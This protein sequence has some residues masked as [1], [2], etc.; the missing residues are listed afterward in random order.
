MTAIIISNLLQA[1]FSALGALIGGYIIGRLIFFSGRIIMFIPFFLGF[2]LPPLVISLAL[3][4]VFGF[5]IFGIG[6][7]ILAH[8]FYNIPLVA[9][10]ITLGFAH[11]PV[12]I[13]R[14]SDLCAWGRGQKLRVIDGY[15]LK[16]FGSIAFIMVFIISLSSF[17]LVATM[18]GG[19]FDTMQSLLYKAVFSYHDIEFALRL[20]IFEGVLY[21]VIVLFLWRVQALR[22]VNKM[23]FPFSSL[24]SLGFALVFVGIWAFPFLSLGGALFGASS[25]LFYDFFGLSLVKQIIFSLGIASSVGILSIISA[26]IIPYHLSRFFLIVPPVTLVVFCYYFDWFGGVTLVVLVQTIV[27]LPFVHFLTLQN[28]QNFAKIIKPQKLLYNYPW[29]Q[30]L[31][32]KMLYL[33]PN[34]MAIFAFAFAFSIGD[35]NAVI[36]L[37]TVDQPLILGLYQAL[38]SYR[39]ADGVLLSLVMIGLMSLP[40]VILSMIISRSNWRISKE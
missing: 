15:I 36:L 17:S 18:G 1:T 5:K 38:G 30:V 3:I 23:H 11:I 39:Q 27:V 10:M 40:I 4:H 7:V 35:Y 22:P 20:I 13:W 25:G 2:F 19:K 32:V 6:G 28:H 31:W 29:W 33:R 12:N 34:F 14:I 16:K 8:I 24:L 21:G 9:L 26:L 37:N